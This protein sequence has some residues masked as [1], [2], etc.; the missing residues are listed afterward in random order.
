MRA[1]KKKGTL[2]VSEG[3]NNLSATSFPEAT[4]QGTADQGTQNKTGETK[5]VKYLLFLH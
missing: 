4:E 3:C 2:K 1:I 5:T